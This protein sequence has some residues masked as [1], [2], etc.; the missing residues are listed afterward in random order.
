MRVVADAASE[1]RVPFPLR[2]NMTA[3][4]TLPRDLT[5]EEAERLAAYVRSLARPESVSDA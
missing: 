3:W 1:L 4:L 2:D 5:G